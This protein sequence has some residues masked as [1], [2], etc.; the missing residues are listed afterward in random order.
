MPAVTA[1]ED[2]APLTECALKMDV[3]MPDASR[4]DFSQR[5]MELEEM[6]S[7]GL[8]IATSNLV[9]FPQIDC[10]LC[11]YAWRHVTGHTRVFSDCD[12]KKE[13]YY[14]RTLRTLPRLF[15]QYI[16]IKADS[17]WLVHSF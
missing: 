1:A 6:A 14:L 10:V 3:S 9:S 7:C 4:R 13:M 5:A 2:D 8:I 12:G 17:I 11:S 15:S 16:W